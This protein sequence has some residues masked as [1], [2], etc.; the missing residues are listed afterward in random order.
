MSLLR[1]TLWKSW[2][3]HILPPPTRYMALCPVDTGVP[4]F[5]SQLADVGLELQFID[6]LSVVLPLTVIYLCCS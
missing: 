2:R 5:S 6:C 3:E 1:G 4:E